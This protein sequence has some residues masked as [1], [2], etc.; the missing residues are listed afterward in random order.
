METVA[1]DVRHA[2][3][4]L[5][6]RPG[7]TLIVILTLALGIGANTGVFSF[8]NALLL[9]PL[10]FR[11]PER[12]VRIAGLRGAEE[13][14]I[15]MLELQDLQRQVNVFES[16]A[17]YA[18]G[19]QYNFSGTGTPEELAA[20]LATRNIFEV[21]GV[22]LLYGSTWPEVAD[23]ERNFEVVLTYD[24]WR[25]KFGGN[26][27]A[28]GQKITLDAAP[29][30]TIHGVLP[31]DIK[32]PDHIAL[33]RSI[34][35]NDRMPNYQQRDARNVYAVARLKPG[36]SYAQARAE[37]QNFGA[38]LAQTY[39]ALN[40]GLS[41]S[42]TPLA[43]LYVGPVRPYLWLLAAAVCCVLLVACGNVVNLLLARALVRER[44]IALRTALGATRARLI[45]LLLTESLLLALLGGALGLGLAAGSV[46]LIAAMASLKLPSWVVIDI[47]GRVLWFTLIV[48]VL[49]G[50]LAGLA[51]ALQAS[52]P[53]LNELL[54]EGAR[55]S[56]G[57]G[58]Q[59]LRRVLVVA[60]IALALAL[61]IGAGLLLRSFLR[62]QQVNLGF[63]PARLLTL[64]LALP[65]RKFS[66]ATGRARTAQFYEQVLRQM[67]ALPG[68]EA[69]AATSNLP[70]S[71]ETQLGKIT[72]TI[73]G[74]S[75][76]EQP[77]NPFV[78][79]IKVSP[80]YFAVMGVPLVTGRYL[81]DFDVQTAERV[82]VVS[83]RFVARLFPNRPSHEVVGKRIKAGNL[84]STS[85]WGTIVGVVKDV[86]HDALIEEGGLDLYSSYQQLPDANMYLLLRSKV[87]PLAL[88]EPATR[89]VWT[90][91]PDQS[92]FDIRTME[93]RIADTIWQ[94]RVAGALFVGFAL[95]ALVLAGVGIYGLLS[96]AVSQRTREIGIRLALGAQPR[97]I[98]Q[99]VLAEALKL[100][101]IG[102]AVGWLAAAVLTRLMGHLL[103]EV[104]ATDP[105]TFMSVSLVLTL[106]VLLAGYFPLRRAL[107]LE[108]LV[109][110]RY[111]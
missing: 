14:R 36:V 52:N 61:L 19:A 81:N 33:F 71:G 70:L 4:S 26:P 68:V 27:Q 10:P 54:K 101:L 9:R 74:Q 63:N 25:R 65:W 83:A 23:R 49:T 30:Y 45:R 5:G 29:F 3:R 67:A 79:D 110:L 87:E 11:E 88:A 24:L 50:V 77:H 89:I 86:K 39:P 15:S 66:D 42:L 62:L 76:A 105:L 1:Q 84:S 100:A 82:Y 6:Q 55:G 48:S 21:L 35:I 53:N 58:R 51:P 109:A 91:D 41:F 22:P 92:T 75:A 16:V 64:R 90:H 12:L 102:G 96:Y 108:P 72:F 20:T 111:E 46:K 93:R 32:F 60:E 69:A 98:L 40:A 57:G 103:Y 44:E 99:M 80:N 97:D 17:A 2:L 73:E 37:L 18:P 85:Q 38:R 56:A 59:Q 95:L 94:R 107:K 8:I 106:V 43:D 104:S 13:G 28:L 31:P 47:D 78:N 34:A 7:F